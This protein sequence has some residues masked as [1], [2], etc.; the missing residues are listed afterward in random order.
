M[1]TVYNCK[2]S[3]YIPPSLPLLIRILNTFEKVLGRN[4]LIP[5]FLEFI[6]IS[7]QILFLL[8]L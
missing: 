6:R 5:F 4:I 3:I 8:V 7:N 2:I 1:L